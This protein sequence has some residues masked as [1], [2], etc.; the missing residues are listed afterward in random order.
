MCFGSDAGTI[1][2]TLSSISKPLGWWFVA[3]VGYDAKE[4]RP[5]T[6]CGT[7]PRISFLQGLK[8][9]ASKPITSGLKPD[10]LK[11]RAFPVDRLKPSPLV[12]NGELVRP[13]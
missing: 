8:P 11:K 4:G 6:A 7:M 12:C 2:P 5:L 13:A 9:T 3:N 10:L 1:F